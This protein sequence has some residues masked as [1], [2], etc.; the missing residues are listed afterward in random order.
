MSNGNFLCFVV[1]CFILGFLFKILGAFIPINCTKKHNTINVILHVFKIHIHEYPKP[2]C[3]QE[4]E[5]HG[6]LLC[7][8]NTFISGKII[9]KIPLWKAI[10]KNNKRGTYVTPRNVSG[11]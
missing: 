4:E 1:L 3:L 8:K 5:I 6:C 9:Y 7:G 10:G 11:F 2:I